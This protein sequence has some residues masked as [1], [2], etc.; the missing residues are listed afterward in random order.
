[1]CEKSRSINQVNQLHEAITSAVRILLGI[2]VKLVLTT[3]QKTESS[4]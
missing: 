1:M 4:N 2:I 3:D